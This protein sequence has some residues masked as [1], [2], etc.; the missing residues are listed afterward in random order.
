MRWRGRLSVTVGVVVVVGM[1][2]IVARSHWQGESRTHGSFGNRLECLSK[3][4]GVCEAWFN[5][6]LVV[7]GG[8]EELLDSSRVAGVMRK[9]PR[10]NCKKAGRACSRE[11]TWWG[12]WYSSRLKLKLKGRVP[13]ME[14]VVRSS[15]GKIKAVEDWD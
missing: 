14:S 6:Q 3:D 4:E 2:A 9:E 7:V 8:V 10:S 5:I 11:Q 12:A 13:S 15:T 1:I